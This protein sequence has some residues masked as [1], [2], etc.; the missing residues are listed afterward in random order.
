ML[1]RSP[2]VVIVHENSVYHLMVYPSVGKRRE[3]ATINPALPKSAEGLNP[4]M[5]DSLER[6]AL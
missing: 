1:F 2:D 6:Q 5:V 3:T 4:E